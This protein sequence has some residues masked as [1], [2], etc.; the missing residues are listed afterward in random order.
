V[1]KY[2]Y[3]NSYLYKWGTQIFRSK[4]GRTMVILIVA[5]LA[6]NFGYRFYKNQQVKSFLNLWQQYQNNQQYEEFIKSVDLSAKNSYKDT[7]PDWEGQFFNTDLKLLF[8][9]ISVSKI[10][11]GLYEARVL[12]IFQ[13]GK[14]VENQFEGLIY[15]KDDKT[16]KIVRVEI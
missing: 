13:R 15:V 4:L 9:D 7:F 5:V 8:R 12:V 6:L 14:D 16:F 1:H 3:K 11:S 10:E 2:L